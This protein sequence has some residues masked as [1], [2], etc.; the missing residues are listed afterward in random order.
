MMSLT[1]LVFLFEEKTPKDNLATCSAAIGFDSNI[2]SNVALNCI[3]VEII[4]FLHEHSYLF[5]NH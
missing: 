5:I 4:F 3:V 2:N 1:F